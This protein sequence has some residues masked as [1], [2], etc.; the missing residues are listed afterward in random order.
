MPFL[1]IR[2]L[3]YDAREKLLSTITIPLNIVDIVAKHTPDQIIRLIYNKD[4][5][6]SGSVAVNMH[7]I[8][9]TINVVL[10]EIEA[11]RRTGE[12]NGVIAEIEMESTDVKNIQE[13]MSLLKVVFSIEES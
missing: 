1:K 8:A 3:E 2:F 11:G 12:L 10:Q 6:T 13:K 9:Q 5:P 4:V 7:S